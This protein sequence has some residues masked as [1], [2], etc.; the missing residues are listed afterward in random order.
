MFDAIVIGAGAGG[1]SAAAYLTAAGKKVLLIDSLDRLGGRASSENIEGFT[2]NL[3]AISLRQGEALQ[4]PFTLLGVPFDIRSPKT[5]AVFRIKGKVVDVT[6]GALG[7][8]MAGIAKQAAKIAGKL[9]DAR[10]GE[11]PEA[12]LSTEQWLRRYTKNATVHGIFRNTCGSLFS[13]NS[14]ELPARTFLNFIG[15]RGRDGNMGFCPRGTVGLWNDLGDGIR[16]AGG[17]I[18]LNAKATALHVENGEVTGL[19]IERDGQVERVPTRFVISNMGPAAT[20]KLGGAAEALGEAYVAEAEKLRPAGM[21]VVNFA[22]RE[23]LVDTSGII[24]FGPTR[25]LCSL[26]ELTATVPELAPDGWHQYVAYS[27]PIPALDD[28]DEATE[29]ELAKQDLLDEFPGFADARMLSIRVMRDDWPAQRA[30]AGLDMPQDT[31]IP[32]LWNVGDAV[33]PLLQGGTGACAESGKRAAGRAVSWLD[34][35][36]AKAPAALSG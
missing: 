7:L 35:T 14:S 34:E 6:K 1:M 23:P 22:T 12:E 9:A 5:P 16:R 2:V 4:E 15:G 29:I 30:C 24:C 31:P 21:V 17:E 19:D 32:N 28:F 25:R 20:V 3:G 33:K 8:A 11:V 27:V 36:K 18:W 26:V 13:V 10:P